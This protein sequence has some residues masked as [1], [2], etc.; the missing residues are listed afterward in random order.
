MRSAGVSVLAALK[1][2][3]VAVNTKR[4]KRGT[5][6]QDAQLVEL[7][8]ALSALRTAIEDFKSD[9]RLLLLQP[10][11]HLFEQADVGVLK[12]VP[13]RSL[14]TA[15]VFTSNLMTTSNGIVVLAEHVSHTAAKR[16]KPKLWFPKGMRA[17]WKL[18]RSREGAGQSAAG[19][20]TQPE[21]AVEAEDRRKYSESN[22]FTLCVRMDH[23]GI[24]QSSILIAGRRRTPCS[25]LPTSST[26]CTSGR[27]HRRR[28]Y[29]M[30]LVSM[31][32]NCGD[33]SQFTFRYVLV[34]IALWIPGVLKSSAGMS[35]ADLLQVEGELN[36]L[37]ASSTPS[38]VFGTCGYDYLSTRF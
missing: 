34:T 18:L 20:D 12:T 31:C 4:Y 37:Q 33:L 35:H 17:I 29:V 6:E 32:H 19:E 28:W 14:Y 1:K 5:A 26:K 23:D 16:A 8:R 22:I 13:L 3:I 25:A 24:V 11:Q 21:E 36:S 7:E 38:E 9:K 30:H 2:L 10:Y 15:Y 27:R